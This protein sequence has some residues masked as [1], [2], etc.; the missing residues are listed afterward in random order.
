MPAHQ[1]THH[2]GVAQVM[3]AD[4]DMT[5]TVY[6]GQLVAKR[7]EDAVSRPVAERHSKPPATAADQE[8]HVRSRDHVAGACLA[9]F[10]QCGD[11][12]RMDRQQPRFGELGLPDRQ[13]P[14]FQVN[15]GIAQV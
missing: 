1:A 4:G 13:E 10:R 14:T 11:R 8:R 3:Q 5:A 6:P 9:V 7:I 2:E 15:I 12:G